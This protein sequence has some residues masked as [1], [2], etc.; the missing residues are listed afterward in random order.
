MSKYFENLFRPELGGLVRGFNLGDSVDD[1]LKTEVGDKHDAVSRSTLSYTNYLYRE[2]GICYDIYYVYDANRNVKEISISMQ[3]NQE[4]DNLCPFADFTKLIDE[5]DK[6]L[7][8]QYGV[9]ATEIRKDKFAG[10]SR[11]DTWQV[12]K[13]KPIKILKVVYAEPKNKIK[14]AFRVDFSLL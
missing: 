2:F 4:E 5:I 8:K 1:V 14:K 10:E 13:G 6:H 9:P 12:D 7:Q 11:F 3:Y